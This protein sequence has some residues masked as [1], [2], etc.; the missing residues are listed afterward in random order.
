MKVIMTIDETS[1]DKKLQCDTV[2]ILILR[3]ENHF[4]GS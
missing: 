4:K 2:L 1:T 3:L